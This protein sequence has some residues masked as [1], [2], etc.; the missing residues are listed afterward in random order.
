MDR[1]LT[2]RVG[3]RYNSTFSTSKSTAAL[4]TPTVKKRLYLRNGWILCSD[5]IFFDI[6]VPPNRTASLFISYPR[7]LEK[8]SKKEK[9]NREIPRPAAVFPIF[10]KNLPKFS[11]NVL[12]SEPSRPEIM[13]RPV[14]LIERTPGYSRPRSTD[15]LLVPHINANMRGSWAIRI[16]EYQ[17]ARQ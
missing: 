10:P 7:N 16:K 9:L 2:D 4:R 1:V 6:E 13:I 5:C 17:I 11:A 12:R 15:K 8:D 14:G 3:Q